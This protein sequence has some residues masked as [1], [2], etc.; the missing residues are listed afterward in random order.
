MNM[1]TA[2]ILV[3][4]DDREI[5]RLVARLLTENG[6]RATSVGDAREADAALVAGA[7]P[8]SPL[9]VALGRIGAQPRRDRAPRPR[10]RPTS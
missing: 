1:R 8:G 7:T 2:H 5:R 6:L 3:V 4:D 10:P 9:G